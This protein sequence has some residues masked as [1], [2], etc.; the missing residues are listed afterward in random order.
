MDK[1]YGLRLVILWFGSISEY[2]E[3]IITLSERGIFSSE[4]LA[5]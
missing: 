2:L 1:V 3:V 4:V 5:S